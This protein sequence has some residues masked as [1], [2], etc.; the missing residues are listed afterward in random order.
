VATFAPEVVPTTAV[1]DRAAVQFAPEQLADD[2]TVDAEIV[3]PGAASPFSTEP[4]AQVELAPAMFAVA[5]ADEWTPV[6]ADAAALP[7][8]ATPDVTGD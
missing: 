8:S 2:A 6:V 4:A 7:P 1:S 3:D 5:P